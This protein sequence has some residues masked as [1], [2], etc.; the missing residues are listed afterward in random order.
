MRINEQE[1]KIKD[2][3]IAYITEHGY[4]P[5][6]REICMETHIRSTSTVNRYLKIMLAKG[7]LQSDHGSGCPRAIRVPGY[8]FKKE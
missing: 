1:K 8:M 3:I 7:I 5:S 2:M 4:P 6:T